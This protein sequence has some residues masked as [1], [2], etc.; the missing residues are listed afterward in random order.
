VVKEALEYHEPQ[1]R[2]QTT[3]YD[4]KLFFNLRVCY[5]LEWPYPKLSFVPKKDKIPD[6]SFHF[7]ELAGSGSWRPKYVCFCQDI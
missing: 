1:H 6:P 4:L 7:V 5:T 2:K 3:S